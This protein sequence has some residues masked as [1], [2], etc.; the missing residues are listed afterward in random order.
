MDNLQLALKTVWLFPVAI[1]LTV[2]IG[3]YMTKRKIQTENKKNYGE[4]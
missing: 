1:F 4:K 2:V 3:L